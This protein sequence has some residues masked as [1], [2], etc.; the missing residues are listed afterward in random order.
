MPADLATAARQPAFTPEAFTALLAALV[1]RARAGDYGGSP[2]PAAGAL[3]R[4][5]GPPAAEAV[6]LARQLVTM[7][8]RRG[9]G[10]AVYASAALIA[11]GGDR[12]A[13]IAAKVAGGL[14]HPIATDELETAS[15]A[16]PVALALVAEVGE[17]RSYFSPPE[18]PDAWERL[19]AVP[20]YPEFTR[21][22]VT[23]ARDR[24][25]EIHAGR[26]RYQADAALAADEVAAVGRAVRVALLRDEPWLLDTLRQLLLDV[27]VAPTAAR[28]LPSQALLY[29]VARAIEVLPTPETLAALREARAVSR[30]KGVHQQLDRKF[31]RIVR[32]LGDRPDI[33][34]RL[35]DLGFGPDEQRVVPV[36]EHEAVLTLTGG[37]ELAWR[38][39]GGR[40][41]ATVPAA[42]RRDHPD[43]VT[44]VRALAQQ[45]KGHLGT[46]VRSLEAGF[47]TGHALPVRRWREEL[48][49]N[50]LGRAVVRR[51][52]WEVGG[53]AVL[54][55]DGGLIGADGAAVAEP[56]SDAEI[57]L[58]HPLHATPGEVAAWRDLLTAREL[59]QPFKQVFREVYRLTPAEEETGTHTNRFA[60][61]IVHYKQ[62][63]A[64]FKARGWDPPMLGPWDAGDTGDATRVL[65]GGAWRV[66]MRH[67]Y[68]DDVD[69]GVACAS[70]D[71]VW[72]D[73]RAAGTWRTV[74]LTEV[75]PLVFSEALRDVDLFV[76]V[77]SIAADPLWPDHHRDYWQQAGDAELTATAE[78]RRAALARIL[79]RTRIAARCELTERHLVVRGDLHTYRIH[80][81]SAN[82]RMGNDYLCIVPARRAAR[83]PQFVPF[84]EDRLSIILSKA[85]LL[86]DDT[87]ITDPSIV[88]QL[89]RG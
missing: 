35:P 30:H 44:E 74:P 62:L 71:R 55:V 73:H 51:L 52:V 83:F 7:H 82:I 89:R 18:L 53:V 77:T 84:E 20:G 81:G 36:G 75:P 61:H 15:A 23:A 5:S 21:R 47:A 67:D 46:L 68:R 14:L 80:L 13:R 38:R 2:V 10:I 54:P 3:L 66:A 56:P 25:A 16:G 40:L 19:A 37:V 48:A 31:A 65:A 45:V 50:G 32:S 22:A 42:V 34:L 43:A 79:P 59:R 76:S 64:L 17:T 1:A 87:A 27:A 78:V 72:F 33:A 8:L 88:A 49:G 69:G 4:C 63:Y 9:T 12:P 70:T 24:L 28:T 11:L 57:R 29:E 41:S 26:A 60:A 39:P 6:R 85:F 86:A 58:W